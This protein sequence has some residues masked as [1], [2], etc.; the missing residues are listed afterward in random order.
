ME[1]AG[2]LCKLAIRLQKLVNGTVP[3]HVIHGFAPSISPHLQVLA[4][5]LQL[6]MASAIK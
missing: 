2:L 5:L 4:T 1:V 3:L 6:G